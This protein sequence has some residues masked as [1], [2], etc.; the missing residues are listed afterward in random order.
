[1]R[2]Q[3]GCYFI[4]QRRSQVVEIGDIAVVCEN[5][6]AIL[7]RMGIGN[8]IVPMCRTTNMRDYTSRFELIRE[9]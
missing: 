6:P 2:T 4:Q 9:R 5:P 7:K 8:G 1:M 3:E